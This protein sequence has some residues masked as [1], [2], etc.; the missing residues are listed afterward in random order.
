M[1]NITALI[2]S[3]IGTMWFVVIITIAGELYTP[4][5]DLLASIAGHHWTTKSIFSLIFFSLLYGVLHKSAEAQKVTRGATLVVVHA[6]LCGL[7]LFA[8]FLWHFLGV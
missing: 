3:T 8:F 2:R 1:S 7:I 4:F 5:K 6:I